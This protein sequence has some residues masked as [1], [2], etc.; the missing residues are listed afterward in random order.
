MS[1]TACLKIAK[2]LIKM[3]EMFVNYYALI[4]MVHLI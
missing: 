2:K 4:D 3:N 1:K